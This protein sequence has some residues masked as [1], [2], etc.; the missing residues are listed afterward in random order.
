[1][2]EVDFPVLE[3]YYSSFDDEEWYSTQ[4]HGRQKYLPIALQNRLQTVHQERLA[5]P[6][7]VAIP[8]GPEHLLLES[9]DDPLESE[10][11]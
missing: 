1:M 3:S 9:H 5:I 2:F 11:P 8:E 6:K 4:H 7:L 10:E